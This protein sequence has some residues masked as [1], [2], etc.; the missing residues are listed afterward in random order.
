MNPSNT[1]LTIP[2][3]SV[4]DESLS[5]WNEF[6]FGVSANKLQFE[7]LFLN[8]LS[9]SLYA[10]QD[11]HHNVH[12]TENGQIVSFRYQQTL[13]NLLTDGHTYGIIFNVP[14]DSSSKLFLEF[15]KS[16]FNKGNYSL[17][18]SMLILFYYF[19]NL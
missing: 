17:Q 14:E 1:G 11:E 3:F 19:V 5:K 8:K 12:I 15:D 6:D 18:Y 16:L 13:S 10:F 4:S 7:L 2:L 9:E